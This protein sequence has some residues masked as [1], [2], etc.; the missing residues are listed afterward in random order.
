MLFEATNDCLVWVRHG[1]FRSPLFWMRHGL[2]G[3]PQHTALC[4]LFRSSWFPMGF[5]FYT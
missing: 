4:L 1:L 3:S 5:Y 2:F